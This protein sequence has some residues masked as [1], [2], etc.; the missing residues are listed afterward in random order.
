MSARFGD[1]LQPA[2]TPA[3]GKVAPLSRRTMLI[4]VAI[5]VG[6]LAVALLAKTTGVL[7]SDS[8]DPTL[9]PMPGAAKVV[10]G[11]VRAG[12]PNEEE[13][14]LLRDTIKVRVVAATGSPTA[15]E[16]AAAK[17]FGLRMAMFPLPA[18]APPSAEQ[19][20]ALVGLVNTNRAAGTG[21]VVYLHG[22]E[23]AGAAPT[24]SAMVQLVAGVPLP[25][26][27]GRLTDAERAAMSRAQNQALRDV[28]DV[29][30]GASPP[31]SQYALLRKAAR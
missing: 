21:E 29:M 23:D 15:E 26:A 13:L 2:D 30:R 18:D 24:M 12:I 17:A 25:A 27:L 8:G 9:P 11:L 3:L 5:V 6:L 22:T 31:N 19:V 28:S 20:L 4:R 14:A 16:R 1:S 10:P 7:K